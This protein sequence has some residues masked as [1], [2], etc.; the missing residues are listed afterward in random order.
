MAAIVLAALTLVGCRREERRVR[1]DPPVAAAL[2]AVAVMPVGIGGRP[3]EVYAAL[4]KPY[5]GNAY[6]LSQGKQLYE[7]FGCQG[8]HGDGRGGSAP[9]LIDGWWDYG[10]DLVSIYVSIRDGRPNGMPAFR[11]RLTNEQLWQLAGY[12]Q[13]LGAYS[14]S[15]AAPSRSDRVQTRPAENR[16]PAAAAPR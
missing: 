7:W 13:V 15:T 16:A 6:Q 9:A 3:P 1:L 14:A 12:V 11:N 4:G 10:P 2:D 8:C 5:R